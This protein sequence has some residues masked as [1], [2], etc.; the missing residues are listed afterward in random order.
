MEG[1]R[2]CAKIGMRLPPVNQNLLLDFKGLE[3]IHVFI[4]PS[5]FNFRSA[6]RPVPP[7]QA[8]RSLKPPPPP[9]LTARGGGWSLETGDCNFRPIFGDIS[10]P[11]ALNSMT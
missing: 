4:A 10:C 2:I 5:G 9:A 7:S 8:P 6:A 3:F 11:C 1:P